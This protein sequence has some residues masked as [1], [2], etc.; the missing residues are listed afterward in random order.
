MMVD[1]NA[2][3]GNQNAI[4]NNMI[5]IM[6]TFII[7]LIAGVSPFLFMQLLPRMMNPSL[8]TDMT[9]SYY[10]LII[11]GF[12]IGAITSIIFTKSFT[13]KEPYEI[14][15]YALGIPALLIATV[16]NITTDFNAIKK[17]DDRTATAT[18]IVTQPPPPIENV[19]DKLGNDEM[20][21]VLIPPPSHLG[22]K[23]FLS[24]ETAWA[25][26]K[27]YIAQS[28]S[29]L[30]VI[31]RYRNQDSAMRDYAKYDKEI[32]LRSERYVPKNLQILKIN[33]EFYVLVYSRHTSKEEA[34]RVYRVLMLN[35]P[36][37]G[38]TILK[39]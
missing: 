34:Y 20:P 10:P 17:I 24:S 8:Y 15:F 39:Y 30:V 6:L 31:G 23:N 25:A 3:P 28:C 12:L 32:G 19:K 26:S 36:Y 37:L 1:I 14:F 11:T 38:I 35:D 5:N 9:L 7:G 13:E 21:E 27:R 4:K 33:K 2:A 16:S 29:Y 18:A 22:K